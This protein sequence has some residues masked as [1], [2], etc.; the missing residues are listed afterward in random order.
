MIKYLMSRKIVAWQE[1]DAPYP[2]LYSRDQI[3]MNFTTF[4]K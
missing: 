3:F 2:L 4:M 1:G